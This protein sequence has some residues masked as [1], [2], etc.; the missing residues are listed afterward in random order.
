MASD[1]RAKLQEAMNALRAKYP[2]KA[3]GFIDPFE[4]I[5][6]EGPNGPYIELYGLEPEAIDYTRA[7]LL[8]NML[9]A[10]VDKK[11][12]PHQLGFEKDDPNRHRTCARCGFYIGA[13]QRY[14][15]AEWCEET[16]LTD[17]RDLLKKRI[18]R[19]IEAS[20]NDGGSASDA[21]QDMLAI[22]QGDDDGAG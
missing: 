22:L 3:I 2:K 13:G 1:K 14:P 12:P 15:H 18:E 17:E 21:I 4:I 5:L 11:L 8:A 20:D 10:I 16:K 9:L 6:C 7:R 19:A